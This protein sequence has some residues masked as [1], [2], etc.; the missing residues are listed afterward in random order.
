MSPRRHWDSPILS[1]ASECAPTPRTGGGCRWHIRL[2][3]RGWGSPNSDDLRKGLAL[4]LLCGCNVDWGDSPSSHYKQWDT[5]T[6]TSLSSSQPSTH[7]TNRDVYWYFRGPKTTITL[8]LHSTSYFMAFSLGHEGWARIQVADTVSWLFI[9]LLL[10][11]AILV[12][13]LVE[14]ELFFTWEKP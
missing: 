14:K 5:P 9:T 7:A 3:V 12:S 8:Y 10:L 2:R 13:F 4:C 6:T 11:G 1:L